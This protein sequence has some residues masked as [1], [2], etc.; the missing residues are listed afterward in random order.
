MSGGRK[1]SNE[2]YVDQKMAEVVNKIE[3]QARIFALN[4]VNIDT[5]CTTY[6]TMTEDQLV[7][8]TPEELALGE[9]RLSS[10]SLSLQQHV[11]KAMAIKNWADRSIRLVV[12]QNY[13]SF[14]KFMQYE[15]RKDCTIV[16][17]EYAQ[18]L[19]QIVSEQ[20]LIIDEFAYLSQAVQHV[21]DAFGR[22]AK[23]R[24]KE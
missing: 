10:F 6:L 24:R 21:S 13:N 9:I 12:A 19:G 5:T 4:R 3:N 18:K 22:F 15:A 20:Q 8:L 2:N 7:K 1:L 11:N 14:D 17:N 23:V 16:N